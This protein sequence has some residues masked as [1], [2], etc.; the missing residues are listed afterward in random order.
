MSLEAWALLTLQDAKEHL[1]VSGNE[2]DPVIEDMINAATLICEGPERG[3]DRELASRAHASE[4]F[5]G[6]GCYSLRLRQYPVTAVSTVEFLTSWSSATWETQDQTTHGLY[7]VQPIKEF[8]AFRG[9]YFPIG[10]QNVRVTYTAG[11]TSIPAGLKNA[12]RMALK[13]LWDV[14]DKQNQSIAS[15]T[16]PGG[17]G[18]VYDR[19]F[20]PDGFDQ[21]MA[22]YRRCSWV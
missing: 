11:L 19:K 20:L 2:F 6:G 22:P 17:Q 14:R 7:I 12:C 5:D 4:V 15:Q 8:I 9:L 13:A 10:S 1:Q 3:A 18:V 21:L 16:F